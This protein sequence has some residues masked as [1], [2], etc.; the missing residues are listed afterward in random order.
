MSDEQN[1]KD[2]QVLL[3]GDKIILRDFRL[4]DIT[5]DYID[6]MNDPVVVQFTESRFHPHSI[7]SISDFV[8]QCRRSPCDLLLGI[9]SEN[10]GL[11]LG[12]IKLGPINSYH[13]IADIGLIVGR[14]THWGKGVASEAIALVRDYAFQGLALHKV[15]A[16]F[17]EGNTGSEKAFLKADFVRE[18]VRNMHVKYEDR[19]MNVIEL[20]CIN[21]K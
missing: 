16:S 14:K 10:D 15:T 19:W 2:H 6:W 13:R 11:H 17:Y 21:A 7:E 18:G 4:E 1:L 9:F 20:G 3:V 8:E 5:Q 12:N